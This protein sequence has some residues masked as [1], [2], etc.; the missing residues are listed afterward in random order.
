MAYKDILNGAINQLLNVSTN[1]NYTTHY[2][3]EQLKQD[4]DK[5]PVLNKGLNKAYFYVSVGDDNGGNLIDGAYQGT[6]GSGIYTNTTTITVK[7]LLMGEIRTQQKDDDYQDELKK[8]LIQEDITTAFAKV[9]DDL[10]S[11]SV[12]YIEY[13]SMVTPL[14]LPHGE[15]VVR[16]D[17]TFTVVYEQSRNIK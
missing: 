16:C 1:A 15:G 9:Y 10:C 17:F 3:W 4:L 14:E 7:A 6:I 11:A 13:T 8:G 12:R 5:R 2:T